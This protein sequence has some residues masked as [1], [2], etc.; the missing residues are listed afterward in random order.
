MAGVLLTPVVVR[1]IAQI[2]ADHHAALAAVLLGKDAVAPHDWALAVQLGIV[3][4][5]AAWLPHTDSVGV[6]ALCLQG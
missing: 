4:P 5:A 2:V 6:V 3:D 1:D